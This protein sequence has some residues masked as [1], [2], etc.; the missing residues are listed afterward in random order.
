M[1]KIATEQEAAN[2][3]GLA[4][5]EEGQEKKSV[6]KSKALEYGCKVYGDYQNTQCVQLSDL[7]KQKTIC[8]VRAVPNGRQVKIDCEFAVASELTVSCIV[9]DN[10][11]VDVVV[12]KGNFTAVKAIGITVS[13]VM[14]IRL[15]PIED[16]T[17]IYSTIIA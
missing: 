3:G 11:D 2:I 13:R 14:I 9:N 17:Y 16:S 1:G 10:Q 12:K 8:T 4:G 7:A 5:V 15:N 6:I